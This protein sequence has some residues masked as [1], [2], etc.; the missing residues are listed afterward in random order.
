MGKALLTLLAIA[1]LAACTAQQGAMCTLTDMDSGVSVIWRPADFEDTGGAMIRVCVDGSCKERASGDPSDP[2][3]R[4]SVQ[5][6]ENIGAKKL[7]VELTVTPVKGSSPVKDTEQAQLTE[8]HPNGKGC[9]P[10]AWV[11]SFRADPVKGLV[12]AEGFS[13]QGK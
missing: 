12:S 11:A 7:P 4:V 5:L 3:G 8:E 1:A 2:I 6:P 9:E 13:L 10:V